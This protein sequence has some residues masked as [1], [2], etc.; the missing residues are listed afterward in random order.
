L[1]PGK[2]NELL[3]LVSGDLGASIEAWRISLSD[4]SM[5]YRCTRRINP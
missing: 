4:S 5:G 3:T 1:N 2:T